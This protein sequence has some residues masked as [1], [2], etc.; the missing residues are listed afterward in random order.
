MAASD[1]PKPKRQHNTG[2]PP[3]RPATLGAVVDR[4]NGVAVT[5]V[6][7]LVERLRGGAYRE[8]AARSVGIQKQTLYNWISAGAKARAAKARGEKV[9]RTQLQYVRFLDA[10]EEAEAQ[11][12]QQDWLR[13]GALA[14]GGLTTTTVREKVEVVT[15]AE[16]KETERILER[17]ITTEVAMPS[18]RALMWRMERRWPHRFGRRVELTGADGA[19][20][21]P[22]EDRA[23]ALAAALE[24]FQAGVAAAEDRAELAHETDEIE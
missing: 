21:V 4:R 20:L 5:A 8:E 3:H 16:G 2:N 23:D 7:A 12:M 24:G 11:A 6:D 14:E 17:T 1:K 10:I 9:E 15:N 18:E 22:K 13:L 19:P